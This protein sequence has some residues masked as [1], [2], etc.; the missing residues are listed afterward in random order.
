M[1]LLAWSTM[2][3]VPLSILL[4]ADLLSMETRYI[5]VVLLV[6]LGPI[7][8]NHKMRKYCVGT[9]AVG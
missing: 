1:R 7:K 4:L 3:A 9:R 2:T 5:V 8:V 6:R